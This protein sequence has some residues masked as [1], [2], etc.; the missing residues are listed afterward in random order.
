[1]SQNILLTKSEL[2]R[3]HRVDRRNRL[4][5]GI[6]PAAFL[7]TG[8]RTIPLFHSPLPQPEFPIKPDTANP[9]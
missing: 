4:L 8:S 5:E 1:M 2:A 7:Q 9:K 3:V 6:E